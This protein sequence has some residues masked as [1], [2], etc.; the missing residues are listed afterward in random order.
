MEKGH[1]NNAEDL[2]PLYAFGHV[3]MNVKDIKKSGDYFL[4]IGLREVVLEETFII[5]EVR[6]GTHLIIA[7][8]S[9]PVPEGTKAP[10]DLMVDDIPTI[11]QRFTELD[12]NP[13]EIKDNGIHTSFTVIEPGGHKVTVNS[14]HATDLPI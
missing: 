5:L 13:T 8:T 10:F 1:S 4:K 9:T 3:E 2:R 7:P 14:S 11:H 12:L 6:G